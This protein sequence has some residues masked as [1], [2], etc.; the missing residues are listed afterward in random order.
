MGPE[1][2]LKALWHGVEAFFRAAWGALT[3]LFHQVAGVFFFV[4]FVLGVAALI[5]EWGKWTPGKLVVTAT[6]T[7]M[8]AW[9][10]V[11][12]FWRGRRN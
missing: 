12:S 6:F 8:F 7:A 4:F 9:F 1:Q 10:T 3:Q 11:E 5:R 2:F